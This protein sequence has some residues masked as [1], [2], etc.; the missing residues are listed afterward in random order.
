MRF[1][2]E[3]IERHV[4]GVVRPS[5]KIVEYRK[6]LTHD[7]LLKKLV[8]TGVNREY[9]DGRIHS[10]DNTG[11]YS[12]HS[13][14]PFSKDFIQNIERPLRPLMKTLAFLGLF[15]I[16]SCASHGLTDCRYFTLCFPS[17]VE[18]ELYM[19]LVTKSPAKVSTRIQPAHKFLNVHVDID[20]YGRIKEVK[21]D[22]SEKDIAMSNEY[23]NTMYLCRS[24]DWW[25]V[26]TEFMPNLPNATR[27]QMYKRWLFKK[28]LL[29]YNTRRFRTFMKTKYTKLK[30]IWG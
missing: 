16:S 2:K 10:S 15:P 9:S 14:S 18:A 21:T 26:H 3:V 8:S 4:A 1:E 12:S 27:W 23:L 25:V 17:L 13:V 28:V 29:E 22:R 19:F 5:L 6:E 24:S 11:V 7:Q 30:S 20:Q